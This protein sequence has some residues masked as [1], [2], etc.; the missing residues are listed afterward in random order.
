M[1]KKKLKSEP[2]ESLYIVEPTH[3]VLRF[4]IKLDDDLYQ[5][6]VNVQQQLNGLFDCA[7]ENIVRALADTRKVINI[8]P[9][10]GGIAHNDF[11]RMRVVYVLESEVEEWVRK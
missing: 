10:V 9:N 11:A 1:N 5:T 3:R 7:K 8:H 6:G 4:E 2:T